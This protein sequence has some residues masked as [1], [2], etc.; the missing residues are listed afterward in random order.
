MNHFHITHVLLA[1]ILLAMLRNMGTNHPFYNLVIHTFD[2]DWGLLV[3]GGTGLFNVGTN[4]DKITATGAIGMHTYQNAWW[5]KRKWT[6]HY[7]ENDLARRGVAN[8]AGYLFA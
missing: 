3:R 6:D 2:Y 1:P 5:G 8:L 7:I 4:Y